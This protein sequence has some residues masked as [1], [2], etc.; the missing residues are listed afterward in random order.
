[1]KYDHCRSCYNVR[2][3]TTCF[4]HT[5]HDGQMTREKRRWN[6]DNLRAQTK[7]LLSLYCEILEHDPTALD[8]I[9]D[10]LGQ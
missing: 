1:M 5:M 9:S 10:K 7:A 2:L 4:A 3:C 6:C 8:F